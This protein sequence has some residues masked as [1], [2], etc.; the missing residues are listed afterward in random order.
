MKKSSTRFNL[1]SQCFSGLLDECD[2]DRN[3]AIFLLVLFLIE[4]F[5]EAVKLFSELGGFEGEESEIGL[6]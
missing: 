1:F 4:V 6:L 3:L 5:V 2:R